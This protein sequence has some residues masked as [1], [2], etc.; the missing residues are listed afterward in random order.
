MRQR[1][2]AGVAL[3]AVVFVQCQTVQKLG[4]YGFLTAESTMVVLPGSNRLVIVEGLVAGSET[5]HKPAIA[6]CPSYLRVRDP[7][8]DTVLAFIPG[9]CN[10]SF[11]SATVTPKGQLW[12]FATPW[13]RWTEPGHPIQGPCK[14][15]V[16]SN[17]TVHAFHSLDATLQHWGTPSLSAAVPPAGVAVYNSD[18]APVNR[19]SHWGPLPAGIPPHK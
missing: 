5:Y 11:A 9:S 12:V 7:L 6:N 17:C 19:S 18:V 8:S 16:T 2:V 4:I 3:A 13:A 15:Q 10:H 1:L 14:G